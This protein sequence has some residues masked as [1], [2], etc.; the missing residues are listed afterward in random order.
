MTDR[1]DFIVSGDEA[2]LFP[3]LAETSKEKRV[4]SIFLA[5]MT[6]I[7]ALAEETLST[8]RMRVGK[9]TRFRAFTEVVLKE[10]VEDG[11][12]PDGLLLVDTGRTQWSALIEAKIGRNEL[13]AE[14][15]SKYAEL[16]KANGIDAVI[17]ISNEFV[18]RADHSPVSISKTLLRKVDLFH[19]SWS[20][21][22]T[23]CEILEYQEAVTDSEQGYLLRQLNHFL[24]HPAT[25]VERF[26]QMTASWK[27]VTQSVLNDEALKKSAPEVE[28]VAASCVAEE[29]DLCLHMSS[30]VGQAVAARIER[31]LSEDPAARLKSL[32]DHL[33]ARH[34]LSSVFRVPH[35]A[36]DIDVC[37]DLAR[38]TIAVSMSLKA[39]TDKKSTKARINWLLRMLPEDD[40]RLLVRA[41][42]PGRGAPT[43]KD[44]RTLRDDPSV[45][46]NDN[47][48]ATPHSFEVLLV[49]NLG[50]R[51]SGRRT[52]IEDIERVVPSFYDLVGVNLKAWQ[53]PPPKPVKARND[54]DPGELMRDD[55]EEAGALP[56]DE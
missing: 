4:A 5:V 28:A 44:V 49:E 38:R 17:T 34:T 21:L 2:R 48:D 42:W 52:F 39:P 6:Q 35:C 37:V 7:P 19:W 25:G 16:A 36:S 22:A 30:H 26:T 27:D 51:F 14:Q 20:W 9:R 29:R 55:L 1:P 33:V 15:V 46:Q 24:A 32:I 50:K 12:R 53:M 18:S 47:A 10:K 45:I 8:V 54:P 43:T 23:V 13:T 41:H 56:R 11:C 40:E 31:K 3:I